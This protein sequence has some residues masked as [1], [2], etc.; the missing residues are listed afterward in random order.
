MTESRK[1][2]VSAMALAYEWSSR[3]VALS[4]LV[5]LSAYAGSSLDAWWDI[6]PVLLILFTGI[7]ATV[8]AVTIFSPA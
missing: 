5:G 6:G 1:R 3:I 7:A 4:L 2:D 8:L